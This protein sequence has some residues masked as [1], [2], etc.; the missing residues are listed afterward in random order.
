MPF[1]QASRHSPAR[2]ALGWQGEPVPRMRL[3]QPAIT[4]PDA[5]DSIEDRNISSEP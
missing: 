5:A 2:S 4:P 1:E 3:G